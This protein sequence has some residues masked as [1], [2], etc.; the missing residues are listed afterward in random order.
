M[1][2]CHLNTRMMR[3]T[4]CKYGYTNDASSSVE[5]RW[6]G[7]GACTYRSYSRPEVIEHIYKNMM[8]ELIR[9]Y[10]EEVSD[11]EL[12]VAKGALNLGC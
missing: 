9:I 7:P 3:N 4:R 11:H 10:E 6:Y 2:A 5:D 12:F 1:G 8:A